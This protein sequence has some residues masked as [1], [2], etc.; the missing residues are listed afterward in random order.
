MLIR[1]PTAKMDDSGGRE[2]IAKLADVMNSNSALELWKRVYDPKWNKAIH[3]DVA[4]GNIP[5][6]DNRWYC[7]GRSCL[8]SC[9]CLDFFFSDEARGVFVSAMGLDDK[10]RLRSGAWAL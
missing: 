9:H 3:G 10:T 7:Y 6:K 4:V 8:R 2:Q 1:M 5:I